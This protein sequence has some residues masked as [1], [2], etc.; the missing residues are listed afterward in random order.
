MKKGNNSSINSP[1]TNKYAYVK[2][3][4]KVNRKPFGNSPLSIKSSLRQS[5]AFNAKCKQ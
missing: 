5:I 3:K 2:T 1:G 4:N